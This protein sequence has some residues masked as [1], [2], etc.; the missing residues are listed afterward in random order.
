MFVDLRKTYENSHIFWS[1][2]ILRVKYENVNANVKISKNVDVNH[3]N[4]LI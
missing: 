3:F 1:S 4:F 2:N